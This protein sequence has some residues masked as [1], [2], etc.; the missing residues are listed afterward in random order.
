M[1]PRS[2]YDHEAAIRRTRTR[3]GSVE[4]VAGGS[5]QTRAVQLLFKR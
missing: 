2:D 3:F 4:R 5:Q 1:R